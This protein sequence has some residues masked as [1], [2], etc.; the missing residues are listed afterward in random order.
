MGCAQGRC[1]TRLRYAPTFYVFHFKPFP[2]R[3]Q[4]PVASTVPK[5]WQNLTRSQNRAKTSGPCF[6]VLMAAERETLRPKSAEVP[7][8]GNSCAGIMFL[9]FL[10]S[11]AA[12]FFSRTCFQS[13]ENREFH[14]SR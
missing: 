7:A 13:S 11:L 2:D 4:E 8:Q 1:A 10:I 3:L 9:N 12:V 6:Q 14:L 5:P